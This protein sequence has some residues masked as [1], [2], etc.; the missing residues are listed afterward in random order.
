[1]RVCLEETDLV[2]EGDSPGLQLTW[3]QSMAELL[4]EYRQSFAD[5]WVSREEL[6]DVLDQ[7]EEKVRAVRGNRAG[8]TEQQE[9]ILAECTRCRED[10]LRTYENIEK[11][12]EAEHVYE[13]NNG[14]A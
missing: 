1:M 7:I 5:N 2:A 14:A 3:L 8:L 9:E 4:R 6:S 12:K 13:E 11:W 10:I